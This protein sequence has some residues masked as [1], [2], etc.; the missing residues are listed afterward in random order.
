MSDAKTNILLVDDRPENLLA[1][2]TV[3]A[4]LGQNLVKAHSSAEAL[5]HL[6]RQDFAAILLDVQMPEIDG[7]ETA[8]LIRQRDR[9]RHT[10]IIFLTAIGTSD[11]DVFRGYAIGA[12]DYLFKPFRPEI[13]KSKVAVF[14]DLFQMR[15]RVLAQAERL[16]A[17]NQ[18]LECEIVERTRA[19]E[20]LRASEERYALMMRGTNDGLWDWNILTNEMYAS[21]R[22]KSMVGYGEH[23]LG[24][25]F[26]EWERR[27]HPDD[28]Q[29]ALAAVRGHLEGRT[30][31]YELEHRLLQKDGTYRWILARGMALRDAQQ[32]P[33]RMVGS[34]TDISERKR[35]EEALRTAAE[36]I[37]DLY[38]RA[39]C[40]Y[41]SLDADGTVIAVNDTELTWLGYTRDEVVG[42]RAFAELLTAESAELFRKN[43]PQLKVRGC[44]YDLEYYMVRKDG[45]LLPVLLNAS[46]I[47]DEAG[48][49]VSS[50]STVFDITDRKAAEL[51]IKERSA[52]LEAVNKELEAFTYSVS[53]DLRAPLRHIDGFVDLL[54]H[55]AA[56]QLDATGAR[57]L[58]T[59]ADAAKRMSCLIDDLLVFSRLG[60]TDMRKTEVDLNQLV[61]EVLGDLGPDIE[62]RS[63]AWAIAPLPH[64]AADPALLRQVFANLIGN[65]VKYTRRRD[66]ARIEIGCYDSPDETVIFVRDNGAGFDMQY[67][68]KLFGVFQRLHSAE[69]FE[70]T[71]IGLANVRRIMAR[72]GG[73]TWAEGAVGQGATLSMSFPNREE[74]R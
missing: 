15:E 21:P 29:R 14:V 49:Y 72:H 11:P 19:E 40:G 66:Q 37:R 2:E 38:N 6:L 64:V 33:Y 57:Y 39:P 8:S 13:L 46:T 31:Q 26:E 20:A 63:I 25:T 36:E 28:R 67:V 69:E 70:G 45:S 18:Q 55:Q 17:M 52:E 47:T 7:F 30:D 59:I 32:R 4:D 42:K 62:H 9:S 65:A 56:S 35:A 22:W 41:H 27:L 74:R 1:L 51:Q 24:N 54:N 43:F 16:M 50:R 12:V 3:L 73:R 48:H 71:G 61:Q 60:R 23:E 53:H 5:R 58:E 10:P 68:D 34:H 44:V